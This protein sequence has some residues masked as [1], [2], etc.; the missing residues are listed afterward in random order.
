MAEIEEEVVVVV[1]GPDQIRFQTQTNGDSLSFGRLEL[2]QG[3][4]AS[5]AWLVNA[6][7]SLEVQIKVGEA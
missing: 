4:A 7:K 2:T 6:G 1:P 5:L 3:Q